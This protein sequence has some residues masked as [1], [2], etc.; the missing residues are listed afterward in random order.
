MP[1]DNL[2]LL[3]CPRCAANNWL[4]HDGEEGWLILQCGSCGSV[5][6][7]EFTER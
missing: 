5:Y 6:K 2:Q 7:L 1:N 3:T 4:N